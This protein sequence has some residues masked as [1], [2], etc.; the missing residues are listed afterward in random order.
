MIAGFRH[1]PHLVALGRKS[2]AFAPKT[3]ALGCLLAAAETVKS[4]K[5]WAVDPGLF[6]KQCFGCE[7]EKWQA[8]ALASLVQHD[9]IAIRSGHGVGKTTFL[10][11]AVLWWLS[12]RY[13][14][15]VACTAPTA[16]QLKDV[17]WAEIGKWIRKMP[18]PLQDQFIIN[19]QQITLIGAEQESFA[20]ARTARR[21][22]PE[23]FQG[24]HSDN[25]LFIVDEASGVDEAIFETGKG[26]MS[27]KGAKT[28]MTGNPT[29]TSGYFYDA[30]HRNKDYW[31]KLA[32]PC[33]AS[34]LVDVAFIKE[35]A[36][37]YGISS[38]IYRIRVLGEFPLSASDGII[39]VSLI[40]AATVR[41]VQQT[42]S[43]WYWGLDI[44]RFGDDRS[45]LIK[46]RGNTCLEQPRVWRQLDNMQ[47][48]GAVAAEYFATEEKSRP[49]SIFVDATG[50]AGVGDRLRQLGLPSVDVVV[51]ANAPSYEPYQNIKA[52]LWFKA[53]EW[54]M[55]KD[56]AMVNNQDLVG[57]LAIMN[58]SFHDK[59]GKKIVSSK[60]EIKDKYKKSPDL[61]DAFVLTFADD[62][63][64]VS[65]QEQIINI[66]NELNRGLDVNWVV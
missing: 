60:E 28:I 32:I 9:R 38:N 5:A 49:K 24:F 1:L 15:K 65:S 22:N 37:N 43:P 30:F 50:M 16:H 48:A 19:T 42:I 13:P 4:I 39:P 33:E 45:V 6:V 11:W 26:A 8:Q 61:A 56:V 3:A 62:N 27:T 66:Y 59:T 21:E 12:T 31:L 36:E 2:N 20:V 46:R 18:K 64:M 7:P 55:S 63:Q 34:S 10:S 58:Y 54:F 29:R 41:E 40:E 53:R 52:Q 44:A 47:L 35:M 25:M 57:E 51:G 23:A 17:L 14:A